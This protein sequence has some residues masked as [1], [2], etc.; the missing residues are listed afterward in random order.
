M[1]NHEQSLPG[2]DRPI[3]MIAVKGG[4]FD[5]GGE[6]WLN[7]ALPVHPVEVDDYWMGKFPVT[8]ALW[9]AVQANKTTHPILKVA[10]AL[11]KV[12]LGKRLVF[13]SSLGGLFLPGF[14]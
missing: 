3:T 8:Q 2:L 7:D 10:T 5:M 1:K 13:P 9:M 12:C 14:L 11:W 6:S 4:E